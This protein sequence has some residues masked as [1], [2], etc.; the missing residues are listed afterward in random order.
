MKRLHIHMSVDNLEKNKIYYS[1][2]F[3]CEP[4][5]V[6][7]DYI[8]WLVDDPAINFAISTNK[9]ELGLNHLGIQV[10][11]D[12]ALAEIEERLEKAQISG[13]KQEEAQCCYAKSE[14]LWSIDPQ[15]II[16]ETYHTME[17]IEVFGGDNFTG[18]T[19]CCTP[20]VTSNGMWATG[21]ECC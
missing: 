1:A 16:W 3:G 9:E 6:K 8:Q 12:E 15:N 10:D 21:K 14:K 11:S 18:G 5:K 17:Q 7:D 13:Q 2:L 20:K 19:G 4:T